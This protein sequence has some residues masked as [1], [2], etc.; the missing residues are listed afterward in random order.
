MSTPN[1]SSRRPTDYRQYP[2]RWHTD[3]HPY[4]SCLHR[5]RCKCPRC[6]ACQHS[7]KVMATLTT[8]LPV[9]SAP[10]LTLST[11]SITVGDSTT[12]S[13]SS[14][15]AGTCVASGSWERSARRQRISKALA[16]RSGQRYLYTYVL[17]Q[18]RLFAV[19]LGQSYGHCRAFERRRRHDERRVAHRACTARCRAAAGV[20]MGCR[21]SSARRFGNTQSMSHG[22]LVSPTNR[23]RGMI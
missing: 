12:I 10:A 22:G 21:I 18:L 20:E 2:S 1:R 8:R 3:S 14:T 13:W 7:T 6:R 19:Q 16:N 11:A 15:Y 23:V 17:E 4:W 5:P 9:P